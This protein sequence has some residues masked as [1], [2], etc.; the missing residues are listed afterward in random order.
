MRGETA[1][2]RQARVDAALSVVVV[3][4]RWLQACA[5]SGRILGVLPLP[6]RRPQPGQNIASHRTMFSRLFGKPKAVRTLQQ[7]PD[8]IGFVGP[9]QGS[10]LATLRMA[11]AQ[12]LGQWPVIR[13]A[14]LPRLQ[15][16]HEEH[17]RNCLVLVE[18]EPASFVPKEEIA[19]ACPGIVP[20]DIFYSFDLPRPLMALVS[21]SCTPVFVSGLFWFECPLLVRKGT[22][23][24]MSAEWPLAVSF[25]YVA[26]K[27]YE[28][29]LLVAVAAACDAG[30]EFVSVY[31]GKVVQLDPQKW[32][33]GLVMDKWRDYS[34]HL[35]S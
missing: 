8:G 1:S 30:F 18:H 21:A 32:W 5:G 9:V 29:A 16:A 13:N 27:N 3:T 31:G 19:A 34:D 15:Y 2:G 33:S 12:R 14:Y 28:D 25:W 23:E 4:G 26:A 11:L 20:L 6:L 17:P 7:L 24:R 35:P 22:S 10:G